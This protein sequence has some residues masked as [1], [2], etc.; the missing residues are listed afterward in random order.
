MKRFDRFN[1]APFLFLLLRV[2]TVLI[3]AAG[4]CFALFLASFGYAA[5]SYGRFSPIFALGI[6][7]L[8]SVA[9]ASVCCYIAL[10]V[11]F[12]LCGRLSRGTAFTD[13]NA[14]AMHRIASS[15]MIAGLVSLAGNVIQLVFLG[16]CFLPLVYLFA[17]SA[18]FL[19]AALVSHALAVLVRRA[20][21]L[22]QESDLTI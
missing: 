20:V 18:A 15:L 2:A 11:F 13:E 16:D 21:S 10:A 4:T 9:V 5:V 17:I 7:G 3:A 14:V 12:R 6:V 19:G 1:D 22:Q 8:L